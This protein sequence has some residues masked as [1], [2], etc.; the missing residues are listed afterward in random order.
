[1]VAAGLVAFFF[2]VIVC[3]FIGFGA[4]RLL[5]NK[6]QLAK[7]DVSDGIDDAEMEIIRNAIFAKKK[8]EKESK[9]K[10]EAVEALTGKPP[11]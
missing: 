7:I 11:K 9:V 10:T 4:I 1:M 3:L 6:K 2:F 8:S 5:N